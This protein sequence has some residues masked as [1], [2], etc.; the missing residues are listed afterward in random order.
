VYHAVKYSGQNLRDNELDNSTPICWLRPIDSRALSESLKLLFNITQY[1]SNKVI[2]F[3]RTI[4]YIITILLRT[5]LESQPLQPPVNHLI[6]ALLN[7][8]IPGEATLDDESKPS[9]PL[10]P[11]SNPACCIQRLTSILQSAL[12][13]SKEEALETTAVPL[14]TLLRRI[15]EIA[16]PTVRRAMQEELLPSSKER[17]QPLG[18]SDTFASHV[19]HLSTSAVAPNLKE[20]I[21]SLLFELSD[22]DP[23]NFVRNVGYGFAAGFLMTHN[24]PMP[25]RT[26]NDAGEEVT[27]VDGQEINPITGQR[28]DKELRDPGPEMTDE[29]KER[30]AER[31]FVLFERLRA[32]GVVNVMNPVEQA[33]REGKLEE[34]D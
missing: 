7:L 3:T 15:N 9:T 26:L 13:N 11:A 12:R 33:V 23:A 14:V 27:N 29:E 20:G 6:N 18:K 10:F 25:E 22:K 16:P 1:Y 31:L 17:D 28:R 5:Y 24:F 34:V 4:P 8:D 30:E 32:T 19:L 21:S 2:Q